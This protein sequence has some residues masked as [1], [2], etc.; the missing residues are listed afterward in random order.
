MELTALGWS[1]FFESHFAHFREQGFSAM[2][3]GRK[4]RDNYLAQGAHGECTCK[5]SGKYRYNAQTKSL[6]PAVGDWVVVEARANENTATIHALLPRQNVCSRKVAGRV[7]E[8]QVLVANIDVLFIV[9]GLDLNFNLKRIE[10]YLLLA[11]ENGA[12][13]VI[14]LNKADLCVELEARMNEVTSIAA[15]I[16]LHTMSATQQL[17]LETLN[18]YITTGKTAVFL[19]S[20][21]VGKSTIINALLG[22]EHFK[23]NTVSELGSRGRHTTTFSE[24][25]FLPNGGMIIDTPGM[26]ELQLWGDDEGL[27]QVFDDIDE[28]KSQ[29]RFRK[30]GHQGEP[31][32]AVQAAIDNGTL[33]PERLNN[34][35]K[36]QKELKYLSDRQTMQASALEKTRWK[37]IS[38][39]IKMIEK[40]GK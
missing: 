34:F 1:P 9:S 28:L 21:G 22:T 4:N 10:R 5:L 17:G 15:G 12:L 37:T 27:K 26:R 30:C 3:I 20:S 33:S 38:Q 29:C 40:H 6:L 23:V 2:R 32:C 8:E 25:M 35:M 16:A 36:M 39:K 14:I 11:R 31:G 18:Q 7:T 19:G 13:P 24:L